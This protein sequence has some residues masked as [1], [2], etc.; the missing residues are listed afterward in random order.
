MHEEG[1]GL[2]GAVPARPSCSPPTS[3]PSSIG[4]AS[5]A[6]CCTL[7]HPKIASTKMR[8]TADSASERNAASG[9]AGGRQGQAR[10]DAQGP[11]HSRQEG[12]ARRQ[13]RRDR[14]R[15]D[16]GDGFSFRTAA[17]TDGVE[18]FRRPHQRGP[19]ASEADVTTAPSQR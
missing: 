4:I 15:R 19:L 7:R 10:C 18:R 3:W 6:A 8:P 16:P 5:S 9:A 12:K 1:C 17:G 14:G 2:P 13:R 11:R